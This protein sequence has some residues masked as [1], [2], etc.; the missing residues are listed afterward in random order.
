MTS[1]K[2]LNVYKTKFSFHY[3]IKFSF[4]HIIILALGGLLKLETRY[5]IGHFVFKFDYYT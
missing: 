3:R 4:H 5:I 1:I 2:L